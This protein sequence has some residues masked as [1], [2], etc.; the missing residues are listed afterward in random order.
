MTE[1]QASYLKNTGTHYGAVAG[2]GRCT[3]ARSLKPQSKCSYKLKKEPF[4]VE[5]VP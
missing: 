4:R 5:D 3:Q 2:Q 1:P